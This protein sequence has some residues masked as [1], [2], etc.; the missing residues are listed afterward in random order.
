MTS[1]QPKRTFPLQEFKKLRYQVHQR[2]GHIGRILDLASFSG[3]ENEW[4]L[5]FLAEH[6]E[7]AALL[8]NPDV[9]AYLVKEAARLTKREIAINLTILEP[10]F[11]KITVDGLLAKY[12]KLNAFW[13]KAEAR[14]AALHTPVICTVPYNTVD[15][16]YGHDSVY[17]LAWAKWGGVWRLCYHF[18]DE[19]IPDDSDII[20]RPIVECAADIRVDAIPAY[21][22]LRVRLLEKATEYSNKVQEAIEEFAEILGESK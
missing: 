6:D 8:A 10:N 13:E 12:D 3:T 7:Q 22:P 4:K 5:S 2:K 19:S 1:S 9:M 14:L 16:G 11:E 17:G 15:N 21:E 18:F 20:T